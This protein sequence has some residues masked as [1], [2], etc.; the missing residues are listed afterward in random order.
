[1]GMMFQEKC[2]SSYV[3]LTDRISLSNCLLLLRYWAICVLQYREMNIHSFS[4]ILLKPF[5]PNASFL[6]PLE[7]SENGF[8]TFSGGSEKVH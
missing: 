7:T 1:M 4:Q 2:F 6:Y 8:L 3:L 5:V